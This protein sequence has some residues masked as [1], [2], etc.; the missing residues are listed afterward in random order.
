VSEAAIVTK[1]LT[2][3]YGK[4][5]G[6]EGLDLEVKK[7][8]VFGFIG[9]NGAGKTTT[10]RLLLDSLRPTS[11]SGTVLGLDPWKDRV[12][13]HKRCGFLPSELPAPKR[14]KVGD[15]LRWVAKAREVD[16]EE[17]IDSLAHRLKLDL[18]RNASDLSLGNRRKIGIVQALMH[19]P[20]L[21]ILDEPTSGLDPLVQLEFRRILV[22]AKSVGTTI[23][24]SSHVL[25]EVEHV[26]DRVGIIRD[27]KLIKMTSISGMHE[28]AAV[29]V[30]IV[31]VN[32]ITADQLGEIPN[33]S[34][35]DVN[36]NKARVMVH[37]SM[38]GLIKRLAR[39]DVV[40]VMS[41]AGD[42]EDAFVEYYK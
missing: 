13:L 30:D 6:V 34:K 12:E 8:E 29:A 27:G 25:D 19:Q 16:A 4:T 26:A 10:I 20:E 28:T 14:M 41:S 2:K 1:G 42:L 37:G 22:E 35:V 11:G 17:S 33:V 39:F 7:G 9:P 36:N 15:W 31:F 23:F 24:L 40:S 18:T 5:V 3:R 32:S 21:V 38:D